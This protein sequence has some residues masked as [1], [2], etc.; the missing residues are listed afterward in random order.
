MAEIDTP[1]DKVLPSHPSGPETGSTPSSTSQDAGELAHPAASSAEKGPPCPE[2]PLSGH[3]QSGR[4][5]A[6]PDLRLRESQ[7]EAIGLSGMEPA[8]SR[9]EE[10]D[11]P[12]AGFEGVEVPAA[13]G[14]KPFLRFQRFWHSL[15]NSESLK[16][17][18]GEE[19]GEGARGLREGNAD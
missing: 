3:L 5:P 1:P 13:P 19:R 9:R 16:G 15:N 10:L 6:I 8:S 18:K 2:G 4:A 17:R 14:E 12:N 7:D 11:Q